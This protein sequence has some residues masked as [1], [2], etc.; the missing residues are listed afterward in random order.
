MHCSTSQFDY[1][2]RIACR[3]AQVR[4]NA[5]SLAISV[6]NTCTCWTIPLNNIP[7]FS[8]FKFQLLAQHTSQPTRQCHYGHSPTFQSPGNKLA[9]SILDFNKWGLG[10]CSVWRQG[11]ITPF[12]RSSLLFQHRARAHK[13]SS[14][15]QSII[16]EI[17]PIDNA[18]QNLD[19]KKAKT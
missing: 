15:R 10:A 14:V 3:S 19:P 18:F 12:T 16:T 17:S 13:S 11:R 5:A 8:P 2:G 1:A 7:C 4:P 6:L 9:N